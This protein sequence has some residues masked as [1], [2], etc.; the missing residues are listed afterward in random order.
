MLEDCFG[1]RRAA[2]NK[3]AS[4]I[5]DRVSDSPDACYA[6]RVLNEY[7]FPISVMRHLTFCEQW[8]SATGDN[9][10]MQSVPEADHQ[11]AHSPRLA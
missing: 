4:G 1:Q 8:V 3:S 10:D 2:K 9:E 11:H 7:L 5:A 6:Q